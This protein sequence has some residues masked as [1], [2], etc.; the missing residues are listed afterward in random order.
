MDGKI[1]LDRYTARAVL[2]S[3]DNDLYACYIRLL[4]IGRSTH[5]DWNYTALA[6]F[7]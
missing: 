7:E 3:H 5:T 4:I 1:N 6:S 2:V